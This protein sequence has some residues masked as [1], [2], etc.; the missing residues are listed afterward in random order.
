[1]EYFIIYTFHRI[2]SRKLDSSD[3]HSLIMMIII[4]QGAL[5]IN[6]VVLTVNSLLTFN[7]TYSLNSH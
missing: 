5:F 3:W 7:N 6:D 4:M 2:A 1:M